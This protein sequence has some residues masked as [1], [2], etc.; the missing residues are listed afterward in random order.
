MIYDCLVVGG[1]ITGASAAHE[2][3]GGQ[4]GYGIMMAPALGVLTAN[5]CAAIPV[6][7][8]DVFVDAVSPDRLP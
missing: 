5:I 3:V 6:P 8:H 4:G 1:G 2:L 7:Q